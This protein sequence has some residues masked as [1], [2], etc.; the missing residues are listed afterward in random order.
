[1][2]DSIFPRWFVSIAST[3][4]EKSPFVSGIRTMIIGLRDNN[5]IVQKISPLN[6]SD[7]EQATVKTLIF[8]L[9]NVFIRLV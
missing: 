7:M 9:L 1:M 4:H 5:G 3:S 8:I 6:I 2:V